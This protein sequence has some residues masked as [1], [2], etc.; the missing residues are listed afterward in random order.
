MVRCPAGLERGGYPRL[1]PLRGRGVPC[2]GT[3]ARLVA[4]RRVAMVEHM[5]TKS[6][7]A[8]IPNRLWRYRQRMGFSQPQVAAILGLLS[9]HHICEYE[10]GQKRPTLVTALK[11]EIVYRVPVAFLYPE[12]YKQL[13][14]RLRAREERLRVKW[15]G[16][17]TKKTSA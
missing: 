5:T 2:G 4:V 11:F 10:R 3:F 9:R 17:D 16:H 8:L 6:R 14:E 12:L 1:V 13:K 7:R 15:K